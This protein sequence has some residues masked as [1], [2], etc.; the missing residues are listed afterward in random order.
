MTKTALK[1]ITLY[2][3]FI[4]TISLSNLII[5][6]FPFTFPFP[7][8]FVVRFGGVGVAIWGKGGDGV[9]H[10][11]EVRVVHERLQVRS[12][13]PARP[14]CERGEVDRGCECDLSAQRFQDLRMR[15]E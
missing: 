14:L 1:K 4:R 5:F 2:F 10:D 8:T 13:E 7:F 15:K 3:E 12:R 11:L 9:V 6:T